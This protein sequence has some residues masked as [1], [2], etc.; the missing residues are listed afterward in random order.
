M[1]NGEYVTP[2]PEGYFAHLER[3]R[4]ESKKMKVIESAR[5]A[6]SKGTATGEEVAVALRGAQVRD[7]G[8][9]VAANGADEEMVNGYSYENSEVGEDERNATTGRVKRR[10]TGDMGEYE[11]RGRER[12]SVQ[13]I[14]IHNQTDYQMDD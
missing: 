7:D 1:F 6:V 10:R 2:V 4:G 14:S 9:V 8:E 11:Q 12:M 13:D 5:Q 3:I